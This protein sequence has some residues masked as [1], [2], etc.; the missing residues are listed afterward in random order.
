MEKLHLTCNQAMVLLDLYRGTFEAS[1]HMAC[2]DQDVEKL[3]R[4]GLV[5]TGPL[6]IMPRGEERV[7]EML[8]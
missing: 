5:T 3:I 1:R 2:V 8:G 7:K 6:R 4:H